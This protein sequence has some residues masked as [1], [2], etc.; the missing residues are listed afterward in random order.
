MKSADFW[1]TMLDVSM[2][3]TF[4]VLSSPPV[5]SVIP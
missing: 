2:L 4:T 3:Q 5:A 1:L